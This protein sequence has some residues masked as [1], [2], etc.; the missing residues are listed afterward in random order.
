MIWPDLS[1]YQGQFIEGYRHG[2]GT[3]Y[4]AFSS[5]VYHGEWSWGERHGKGF[6]LYSSNTFYD[7]EW[8][9]NYR[10]GEGELL[11]PN[12]CHY[13]GRWSFH[14][15]N[16]FGVLSWPNND[17]S[18]IFYAIIYSTVLKNIELLNLH[19]CYAK[20]K[21]RSPRIR[22]MIGGRNDNV[23]HELENYQSSR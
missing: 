20:I 18:N 16:G 10:E 19:T 14:Q 15:R 11:Y 2:F 9:R 4:L 6:L 8:N 7:G 13:F 12:D 23:L 17:V 5:T 1:W 21:S 3:F 22:G